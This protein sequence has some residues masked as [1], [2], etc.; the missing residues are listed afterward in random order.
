MPRRLP[1]PT[2]LR[3]ALAAGLAALAAAAVHAPAAG[4]TGVELTT[5][6]AAPIAASNLLC[7]AEPRAYVDGTKNF[8]SS[9]PL[10]FTSIGLPGYGFYIPANI[11]SYLDLVPASAAG[12]RADLCAGVS[13]TPD[14]EASMMRD[15]VNLDAPRV[16]DSPAWPDVADTHVVPSGSGQPAPVGDDPRSIAITLPAG[17]QAQ[18]GAITPCTDA[19]FGVGTYADAACPAGAQV[20]EAFARI[21][22]YTTALFHSP[23]SAVKLYV[24][25]HGPNELARLGLSVKPAGTLAPVKVVARVL[26]AADGSGRLSL[27]VASAP[28]VS[29]DASA[30]AGVGSTWNGTPLTDPADPRVGQPLPGSTARQLYLES[31]SLRLWGNTT[32]HPDLAANVG[33]V[34]SACGTSTAGDASA[35]TYGGTSSRLAAPDV[36]AS[37]CSALAL[38]ATT[39]VTTTQHATSTPTGVTASIDLPQ[40]A[41]T[42]APALAASA[43][44]GL[45]TGLRPGLQATT[46][47]GFALC[48]A[49]QFAAGSR[50]ASTC[51]SGSQVGTAQLATVI[52]D[53]ALT[54][55]ISLG[56][57]PAADPTGDPTVAGDHTIASVLVDV[58][59]PGASTADAP[60]IKLAGRLVGAAD[61]S[62]AI[63]FDALP[64]IRITHLDL[65]FTDGPNALFTTPDTCG[66]HTGTAQLSAGGLGQTTTS[67]TS[68]AIA[69][70]CDRA[71]GGAITLASTTA[72]SAGQDATGVTVLRGDSTAPLTGLAID[73]PA[74]ILVSQT[75]TAACDAAAVLV[76]GCTDDTRLGEVR[77][78]AGPTA[79][80]LTGT[81]YRTAAPDAAA[82]AGAVIVLDATPDGFA[83][84]RAAIAVRFDLR[85]ADAGLTLSASL[86][87]TIGGVALDLRSIAFDLDRPGAVTVPTACGPLTATA[88]LTSTAGPT[89]SAASATYAS[90]ASR[91]FAPDVAS[92][93]TTDASGHAQFATVLTAADG[94]AALRAATLILPPGIA[95]DPAAAARA[96]GLDQFTGGICPPSAR[97]GS[98]A[99]MLGATPDALAGDLDL[100]AI[101]G[102]RLP[103]V[104]ITFSGAYGYRALG[105]ITAVAGGRIAVRFADLA[106]VP[107]NRFAITIDGGGGS[108]LTQAAAGCGTG[109]AW[110]AELV[111][112]GGQTVTR[113]GGTL[114][115]CAGGAKPGA[116]PTKLKTKL[117]FSMSGKTGLKL[118]LNGFGGRTLVSAKLTLPASLRFDAKATKQK[119][120]VSVVVLG[121]KVRTSFSGGSLTMLLSG[122]TAQEAV[123]RVRTAAYFKRGAVAKGK[124]QKFPVRLVFSDGSVEARVASAKLP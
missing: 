52:S 98:A 118:K 86:P 26:L 99:A 12:G 53:V 81:L 31:L 77:L 76:A 94:D 96:C 33:T 84:G 16:P 95:V 119:R 1:F 47:P 68:L 20:G 67:T 51:P 85:A 106:D 105:V 18:F 7:N 78:A 115:P 6:F 54:G 22:G 89:T 4:A 116:A 111:G 91:S 75:A 41:G 79:A 61:G 93:V 8:D 123:A 90:C 69:G 48:S 2:H 57:A 60:R 49:A 73:L 50:A 100:V 27:Q 11:P 104:G 25:G 80:P 63:V 58:S 72:A 97:A 39:T 15:F 24:L 13:F 88:T 83:L 110:S 5:A 62:T 21:S 109:P 23:L 38:P 102:Q 122:G 14:V 112:Q 34:G 56:P 46:A 17:Y 124:L 70:G 108:L 43:R 121:S 74:G 71:P 10:K 29:Y 65:T 19:Q 87:R 64:A 9:R 40:P 32:D 28:R 66:D 37:G 3:S 42:L 36:T 44:V 45:P 59:T 82:A 103:G 114:T 92:R 101:P 30:I 120:N 55:P 117:E 35:T 107:M 113:S